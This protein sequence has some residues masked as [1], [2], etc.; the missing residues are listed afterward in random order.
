[1]VD[2]VAG[3][4][5]VLLHLVEL[6]GLDRRQ[7]IFLGFDRAVLQREIDFRE[8]DRGGVGAAGARHRQIGRHIRHADL[9]ALHVGAGLDRPVR[10]GVPHAVVSHCH[11]VMAGLVLVALGELLE[12]IALGVGQQMIGIAEG[13]GIIG[14][15]DRRVALGRKA[16]SGNDDVDRAERKALVDIG[17]LAKLRGRIDVDRVA[18]V[19][20][21]VD[22][23]RG[24]DRGGVEWL[25]RFIDMGPFELGL[26]HAGGGRGH[27]RC[28]RRRQ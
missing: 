1:M 27:Q 11:D 15:A 6:L 12:D 26:G 4:H 17:F 25:G 3:Q 2:D 13:V 16:R 22:F 23:L 20:P 19:G 9:E 8:G 5:D 7:R 21:L 10:R 18:V 24:P 14:H 28:G